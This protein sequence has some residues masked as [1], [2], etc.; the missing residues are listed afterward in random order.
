MKSFFNKRQSVRQFNLSSVVLTILT[1]LSFAPLAI[2]FL[3]TQRE[4]V[5]EFGILEEEQQLHHMEDELS[6]LETRIDS[7]KEMIGFVSQL[8]AVIE[9]LDKGENWGG[10]IS[11]RDAYDRYTGVLNRAFKKYNDVVSIHALDLNGNMK[12]SLFKKTG[13]SIYHRTTDRHI[14]FDSDFLR[15]TLAMNDKGFFI[16]P[17]LLSNENLHGEETP[18]LLL[19][20]F[21]PIFFEKEKIG[22]FCSDIDVGLLAQAF[23]KIHW[24]FS[25]GLYLFPEQN[26]ESAFISFPGLRKIF[27]SGEAEVWKSNNTTVAWVP[28]FKGKDISLVLW[29]GKEIDLVSV[30]IARKKMLM[31]ILGI[32]LVLLAIVFS[33]AFFLSKYTKSASAQFLEDLE[34]SILHQQKRFLGWNK[35]IHELSEFDEK[36]ASIL[37]KNTILEEKRHQ[38]LKE[39]QKTLDEVKILR[40]ILPI[41][42]FC[43]NIRNDDGYYE[44]IEGY[45]HKHSGVDFSHTICPECMKEHY[46]EEYFSIMNEKDE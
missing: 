1:V 7:Y 19:R 21:T 44:Q 39:L 42:S 26:E 5:S 2:F 41:C 46:P 38:A 33:I 37:D 29:A 6:Q 27:I 3:V 17:L 25:S 11:Q 43:K 32:F 35:R 22:V 34:Q 9:I 30:Q 14:E 24:V 12:F 31:N 13:T 20:I 23:P 8:P 4:I 16:S 28:F 45:I 15:K 10:N 36:V 40:G 18:K